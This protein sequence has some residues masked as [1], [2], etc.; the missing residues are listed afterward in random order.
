MKQALENDG[1]SDCTNNCQLKH[2]PGFK[3]V[4]SPT[5]SKYQAEK[6]YTKKYVIFVNTIFSTRHHNQQNTKKFTWNNQWYTQKTPLIHTQ[7]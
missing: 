4:I 5:Q 3:N 2:K 1:K 7:K 6:Y